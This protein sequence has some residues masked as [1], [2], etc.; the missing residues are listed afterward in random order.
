[1]TPYFPRQ[2]VEW[3]K[4]EEPKAFQR[5]TRSLIEMAV[6]TGVLF[7]LYRALAMT[8]GPASNWVYLAVAFGI[9]AAFLFGMA[10]LHL[11]NYTLRKWLWRAP[12]FG[13]V[14]AGAESLTSLALILA[15]R[16]PMGSE[17]A[18]FNNWPEMAVNTLVWRVGAVIVF[19]V[20]LA[21]VVQSVRYM[22]LR[23]ENR[24]HTAVAV[25]DEMVK[26]SAEPHQ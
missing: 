4:F 10:T 22:L 5:F 11:G 9:G 18:S 23:R 16:E 13:A 14:E 21:A 20:L 1:M 19:A 7:R 24:V 2:T 26:Q 12:L 3:P 17:R 6:I 15:R 8:T 25:H